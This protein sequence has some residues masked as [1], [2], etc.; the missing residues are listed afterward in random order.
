MWS[1]QPATQMLVPSNARPAGG[2][3][4]AKF[5]PIPVA[6]SI[7]V[8]L[9]ELLFEVQTFVPSKAIAKGSR[10]PTGSAKF[11]PTPVSG[12]MRATLCEKLLAVHRFVPSNAIANGRLAPPGIA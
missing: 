2:V 10:A 5:V 12:S 3:P 8:T 9:F 6:G 11:V 1:P 7:L 4:S